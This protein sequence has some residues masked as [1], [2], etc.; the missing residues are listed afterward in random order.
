MKDVETAT[1]AD[2]KAI[3]W[4]MGI[5]ATLMIAIVMFAVNNANTQVQA[6]FAQ[7]NEHGQKIAALEVRTNNVDRRLDNIEKKLDVILERMP[8]R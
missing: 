6:L 7:E 1:H 4:M 2:A 8:I 5:V 3:W